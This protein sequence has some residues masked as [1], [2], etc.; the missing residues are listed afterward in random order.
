MRPIATRPQPESPPP[1]LPRWLRI[2]FG[3]ALGVLIAVPATLVVLGR[4][5]SALPDTRSGAPDLSETGVPP[6]ASGL[7]ADVAELGQHGLQVLA[8]AASAGA[9]TSVAES[10]KEI[11][12]ALRSSQTALEALPEAAREP[13]RRIA[14]GFQAEW[15]TA[16]RQV[17]ER[18][19]SSREVRAQ[20]REITLELRTFAQGGYRVEEALEAGMERAMS[21]L[22]SVRM[23]TVEPSEALRLLEHSSQR[24][25]ALQPAHDSLTGPDRDRSTAAARRLV[26]EFSALATAAAA[27]PQWSPGLKDAVTELLEQL[28]EFTK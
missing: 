1:G 19:E 12:A 23:A 8:L 27:S 20:I 13:V 6:G 21:V 11:E 15:T 28:S 5:E 26:Q 4:R 18:P 2:T 3:I 9:E 17:L 14:R 7:A 22:E 25:G 16:A 10:L 24:L